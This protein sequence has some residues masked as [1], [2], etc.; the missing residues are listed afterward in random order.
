MGLL[1]LP[2]RENDADIIAISVIVTMMGALTAIITPVRVPGHYRFM[3]LPV[4]GY[5]VQWL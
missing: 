4:T 1:S 2:E 3:F 5:M